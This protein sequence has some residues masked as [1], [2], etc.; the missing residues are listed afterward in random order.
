MM[1]A[2]GSPGHN[3]TYYKYKQILR[4]CKEQ[5]SFFGQ[6]VNNLQLYTTVSGADLRWAFRIFSVT[7]ARAE[8]F[9][10]AREPHSDNKKAVPFGTALLL[11]STDQYSRVNRLFSLLRDRR[12]KLRTYFQLDLLAQSK[13]LAPVL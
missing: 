8:G 6:K 10:S 1:I 2:P 3:T 13:A 12:L 9:S 5:N 4:K 11:N 7:E